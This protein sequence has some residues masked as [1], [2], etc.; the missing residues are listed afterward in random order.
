MSRSRGWLSYCRWARLWS[1][2]WTVK[3][4]LHIG[5][6]PERQWIGIVCWTRSQGWIYPAHFR[7]LEPLVACRQI[8]N[9]YH[10]D[11][12]ST[13]PGGCERWALHCIWI[14]LVIPDTHFCS[15]ATSHK[16]SHQGIRQQCQTHCSQPS[17]YPPIETRS[18]SQ[19]PHHGHSSSA[20][21]VSLRALLLS[22]CWR[23]PC[24]PIHVGQSKFV[25]VPIYEDSRERIL[26]CI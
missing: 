14:R 5:W 13:S 2:D 11:D 22:V 21:K 12:L 23:W 25:T 18:Y 3:M 9:C 17:W 8:W 1:Y 7:T 24:N 6:V 19:W 26:D 4:I 10:P 16:H 20:F 15:A